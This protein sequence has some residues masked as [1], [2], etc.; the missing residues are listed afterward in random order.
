MA[1]EF[2]R[3]KLWQ[4]DGSTVLLSGSVVLHP[5]G[6]LD[7]FGDAA[8][9]GREIAAAIERFDVDAPMG[10]QRLLIEPLPRGSVR[11]DKVRWGVTDSLTPVTLV[12]GRAATI[13]PGA[14]AEIRDALRATLASF[15][16]ARAAALPLAA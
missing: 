13:A 4:N 9:C 16:A 12:P 3:M 8:R 14:P 1:I 10:E 6:A 15:R 11:F 7:L 2:I 5:D